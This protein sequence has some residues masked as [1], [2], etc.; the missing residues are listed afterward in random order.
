MAQDWLILQLNEGIAYAFERNGNQELPRGG[1]IVCP[2]NSEMTVTASVLGS[3]T[4]RGM[5]I[6]VSSLT[7]FLTAM[8]RQCLE[9]DVARQCAP[10]VVIP[11]DHPLA[12]RASQV[13]TQEMAPTVSNRLAFAQQVFAEL[14]GAQLGDAV[15][16]RRKKEKNQKDAKGRLR[17]FISEIPESEL[18]E[19][20][21]WRNFP[22]CSIAATVTRSLLV[23]GVKFLREPVF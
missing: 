7:G 1:V 10:Y 8:E 6:R 4:F 21:A 11:A 14:I 17:Q 20:L 2:P 23:S 15:D 5:A 22:N 19:F 13:F 18:S 16:K 9:T 12:R 3:A